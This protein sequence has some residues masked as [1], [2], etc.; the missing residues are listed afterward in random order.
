MEF[1]KSGERLSINILAKKNVAFD[2]VNRMLRHVP[3]F[4]QDLFVRAR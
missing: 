1:H 3:I 4:H 2:E